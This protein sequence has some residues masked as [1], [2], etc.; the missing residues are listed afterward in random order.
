[1]MLKDTIVFA[2]VLLVLDSLWISFFMKNKYLNY[3]RS[4]NHKMDVSLVS[5]FIAYIIMILAYPMLIHSE[6]FKTGLFRAI[7]VGFIIFGTY[8]FT[9]AAIFPKYDLS[10][11]LTETAWGI[12]LYGMSFVLSKK[13]IEFAS[14][15]I[16]NK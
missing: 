10:F 1:M 11:A 7:F 15:F 9:L 4:I 14:V 6:S 12:F 3:F 2:C 13:I 16:K 8:G 5:V